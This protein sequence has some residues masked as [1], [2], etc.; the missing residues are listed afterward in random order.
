MYV[1]GLPANSTPPESLS[2]SVRNEAH[3]WH[4][5]TSECPTIRQGSGDVR[6]ETPGISVLIRCN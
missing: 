3:S 1:A 5:D 6:R 2:Q 4:D